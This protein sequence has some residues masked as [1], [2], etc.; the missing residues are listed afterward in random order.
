MKSGTNS[1]R[2]FSHSNHL[3]SVEALTNSSGAVVERYRYDA[4]GR[5]RVYDGANVLRASSI[6]AQDHGFTGKEH[7]ESGLIFFETRYFNTRNGRFMSRDLAGYVDGYSLYAGYFVPGYLDPTGEAVGRGKDGIAP[8]LPID[9][10]ASKKGFFDIGGNQVAT[11]SG[12]SKVNDTYEAPWIN[13]SLKKIDPIIGSPNAL[14]VTVVQ[15]WNPACECIKCCDRPS[16]DKLKDC[17][18]LRCWANPKFLIIMNVNKIYRDYYNSIGVH[19]DRGNYQVYMQVFLPKPGAEYTLE[20][21]YGHEQRHARSMTIEARK[22][23]IERMGG[24]DYSKRNCVDKISCETAARNAVRLFLQIDAPKIAQREVGH[25]NG[26]NPEAPIGSL[27]YVPIGSFPGVP[28]SEANAGD[29]KHA[30]DK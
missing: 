24:L 15:S 20:N 6:Y 26:G 28:N 29:H 22:A 14:G 18:R 4:Y 12:T 3:F 8:S 7:D 27:P 19:E 30:F 23:M 1:G 16:D 10:C 13:V 17:Y 11:I 21:V 5:R 9:P 2:Y 25:E